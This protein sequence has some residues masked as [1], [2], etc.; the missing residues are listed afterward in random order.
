MHI[1]QVLHG[2]RPKLS[3]I[4]WIW[5]GIITYSDGNAIVVRSVPSNAMVKGWNMLAQS[6]R[7]HLHMNGSERDTG[8]EILCRLR[9][10]A[11]H[12]ATSITQRR[13]PGCHI[14]R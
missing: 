12:M 3:H 6:A 13:V 11:W 14:W 1:S 9:M 2:V 10:V 8:G 5:F 7:G 4:S